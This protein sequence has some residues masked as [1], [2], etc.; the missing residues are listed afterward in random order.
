VAKEA[1][2]MRKLTLEDIPVND[3][4]RIYREYGVVIEIH[5]GEIA[6]ASIEGTGITQPLPISPES[7]LL[8]VRKEEGNAC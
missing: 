8:L 4:N 3:F 7:V 5:S 1:N 2:K 6:R